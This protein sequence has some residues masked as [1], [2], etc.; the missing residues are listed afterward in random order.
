M[1]HVADRAYPRTDVDGQQAELAR[2]A[3]DSYAEEPAAN[4]EARTAGWQALGPITPRVPGVTTQYADP[5]TL[6]GPSTEESGRVTALAIDPNCGKPSA[7]AAAPCRLWVAASGGGIWR[8]DNALSDAPVWI[9][10]PPGVPTSAFGS[11]VIDPNDPAANT[12][13]AGSGEANGSSEN[14]GGL[15]LFRSVDGG[16]SWQLLPGSQP[17][18]LNRAIGAIVVKPGDPRSIWIGT[19]IARNGGSSV[20]GGEVQPPGAPALGVYASKDAGASFTFASDLHDKTPPDPAIAAREFGLFPGGVSKLALDPISPRTLYAAIHGYG[21]WRSLDNGATWAQV[22]HPMNQTNVAAGNNDLLGDRTEF[23]VVAAGGRSRIYLGDGSGDL[24]RSEVWRTNNA[25]AL[26][27]DP[28]G[29]VSNAAWTP[30]SSETNGTPGFLPLNYCQFQCYFDNVVTSP[31][32]ELG[33]VPGQA[34]T[35]WLGGS[36]YFDELPLYPFQPPRSNGRSVMRSVNAGGGPSNIA[37]HDMT[38]T[39]AGP[40]SYRFTKGVHVDQHAIVFAP[41]DPGIAFVGSDGGVVRVDVRNPVDKSAACAQR[42]FAYS[43]S[44]PESLRRADLLDCQRL[45]SAIPRSI[46][47]IND[48]LNDIQFQSLSFN[49]HNP[50]GELLGGTQD[51]GTF[52]YTGSTTWRE[53]VGG[54]GGQSGFDAVHPR[55]RYHNFSGPY[56]EVNLD[57]ND[58]LTW[59]YIYDPLANSGE[60]SSFYIPFLADPVVGGRAFTG[61][62]HVWRTDDNGG[63]PAHLRAH[64][65]FPPDPNPH[66]PCGDWRPLG[67]D[68]TAGGFGDRAG[69]VVSATERAPSDERTLWT[70]TK[71]GRLFVSKNADASPANVRFTR[72]D[73]ASTP[74]RFVSG[75]AIDVADPNHAWI[76][77][78]GFGAYTP[79]A[80]QH[81]LEARYNPAAGTA[82]FVDLSFDLGDQ[83]ITAIRQFGPTGAIYVGTDFGVLRLNP[84][85]AHWRVA[86]HGMPTAAIYGLTLAQDARVLYAATHGRG[87]WR[88]DL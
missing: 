9:E 88:L 15:G 33:M 30:L 11:L 6:T 77:Y 57:G 18:A 5:A 34:D 2:E 72:I 86:S 63:D 81:V 36:M 35:V 78:N 47:P 46:T 29:R 32:S 69:G 27:G 64:C 84:G 25:A 38:A 13:Y 8:T 67:R 60:D 50:T 37:W 66:A 85:A 1:E 39:L 31:A 49:P 80:R 48:G 44:T 56:P 70:S 28:S 74:E 87:A 54:D 79:R 10:P 51:N 65:A 82:A 40:P 24:A 45:L 83:P 14:E 16:A 26:H 23:D 7:T 12:L 73:D 61:L 55:I 62:Q 4:P 59:L 68:L 71:H 20:F 43:G 42:R 17:A 19:A 3:F 58:P 41:Q 53:A 21:L 76:S 22:F 52:A 75:I